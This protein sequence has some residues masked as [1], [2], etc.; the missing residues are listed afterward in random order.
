MA[1]VSDT[2]ER[3]PVRWIRGVTLA[4][5]AAFV[6]FGLWAMISPQSVFD[7]LS[8]L[9]LALLAAGVSRLRR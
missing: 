2:G 4:G 6:F 5:G 9:A 3:A 7:S 8:V 1:A